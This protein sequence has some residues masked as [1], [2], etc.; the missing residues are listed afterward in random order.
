M[1]K[2][3]RAVPTQVEA[4]LVRRETAQIMFHYAKMQ[5][6]PIKGDAPKPTE[7][8]TSSNIHGAKCINVHYIEDMR[9]QCTNSVMPGLVHGFLCEDCYHEQHKAIRNRNK[10]SKYEAAH[11]D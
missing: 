1:S 4:L 8:F 2:K 10:D 7:S 9:I 3:S 11:N 6:K 5:Q